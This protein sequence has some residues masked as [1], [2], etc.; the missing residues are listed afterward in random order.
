MKYLKQF[1]IITAITFIG[2]IIKYV[3]P[4]PVPASIYGMVIMFLALV[5]GILKL[6]DGKETSDFLIKIMPVRFISA[7]AGI[8]DSFSELYPIL[9][10]VSIITVVTIITV[11]VVT[12]HVTQF[13]IGKD[14]KI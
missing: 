4:F 2:E 5:S 14:K 6:D 11:M 12:G 10:K 1:L 8:I 3:L 13:V 9:L 7:G